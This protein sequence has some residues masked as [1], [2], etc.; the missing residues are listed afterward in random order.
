MS[1][2]ETIFQVDFRFA[3]HIVRAN[4]IPVYDLHG[5]QRILRKCCLDLEAP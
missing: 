4:Q 5:E 2:I 1:A 3:D